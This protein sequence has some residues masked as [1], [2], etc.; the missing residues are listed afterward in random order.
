MRSQPVAIKMRF[1]PELPGVLLVK[2]LGAVL[3]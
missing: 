2:S 3:R 1:V